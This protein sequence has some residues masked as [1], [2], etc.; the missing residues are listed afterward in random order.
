M[1]HLAFAVTNLILDCGKVA[2]VWLVVDEAIELA[3]VLFYSYNWVKVFIL[4][5]MT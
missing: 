2:W 4:Q 1:F 5:D 3:H